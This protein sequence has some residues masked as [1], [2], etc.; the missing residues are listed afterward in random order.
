M[1]VVGLKSA[2]AVETALLGV[3]N[4][5]TPV[6]T[7]IMAALAADDKQSR[8]LCKKRDVVDVPVFAVATDGGDRWRMVLDVQIDLWP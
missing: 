5:K 7:T 4:V 1:L 2:T 3:D 6:V 8:R